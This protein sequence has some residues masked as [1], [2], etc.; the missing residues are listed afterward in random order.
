MQGN[1]A[2]AAGTQNLQAAQQ[3]G[4]LSNQD[5]ARLLQSGQAMGALGQQTQQMGL[6]NI[7]ALEA[8][9]AGQQQ[10]QQR[11]LD[12]AYQDFLNQREY[13]RNNIGFLNAAVRGLTVPTSTTTASNGPASVYQPSPLSQFGSALA[14]GY[15]LNKMF[16]K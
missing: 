7:A 10:Q 5:F 11:S 14:T 2:G 3:I 1:L 9:G 4:T 8:A 13:D 6:Q 16:G 15:G 12:T